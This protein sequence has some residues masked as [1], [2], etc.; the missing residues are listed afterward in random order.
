M[1]GLVEHPLVFMYVRRVKPNLIGLLESLTSQRV[2]YKSAAD[3]IE[4]IHLVRCKIRMEQLMH[5]SNTLNDSNW[6]F[7]DAHATV[8]CAADWCDQADERR[9]V[10]IKMVRS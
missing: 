8:G 1:I 2:D 9:M 10:L 7:C 3:C 4:S 6:F 5:A